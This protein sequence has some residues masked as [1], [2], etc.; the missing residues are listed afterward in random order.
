MGES[1]TTPMACAF[2]Q[3]WPTLATVQKA[4]AQRLRKFYYGQ[5]CRAEALIQ[6]GKVKLRTGIID[7][8]R[9]R[10]NCQLSPFRQFPACPRAK[11]GGRRDRLKMHYA[12][13][14][15]YD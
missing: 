3:K 7:S 9:L 6:P 14:R 4:G 13:M 8:S 12:L 1:L 2:L 15:F 11:R 10:Q 5:H